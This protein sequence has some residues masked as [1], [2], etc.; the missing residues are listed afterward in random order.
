MTPQDFAKYGMEIVKVKT[1]AGKLQGPSGVVTE[2]PESSVY[3]L[4]EKGGY[5][6]SAG[7]RDIQGF[8]PSQYQ[9][10]NIKEFTTPTG[11][12]EDR[13][14]ANQFEAGALA[15]M[16]Y[17][18]ANTSKANIQASELGNIFSNYQARAQEEERA[19]AQSRQI[20]EQNRIAMQ[21]YTPS[22][23]TRAQQIQAQNQAL[24]GMTN[25]QI[26]AQGAAL[27]PD[28]AKQNPYNNTTPTFQTSGGQPFVPPNQDAGMARNL[29]AEQDFVKGWQGKGGRLP[30]ANEI[31]QAVYG[32]PNPQFNVPIRPSQTQATSQQQASTSGPTPEQAV[33]T[34]DLAKEQAFVQSWGGK[35]GRL[36]TAAEINQGV[37]GTA[38]PQFSTT[39][40]IRPPE[41]QGQAQTQTSSILGSVTTPTPTP[42]PAT[43]TSPED[44]IIKLLRE[45]GVKTPEQLSAQ[46][47]YDATMKQMQDDLIKIRSQQIPMGFITGQSRIEADVMGNKLAT[48]EQKLARLAQERSEK[49][50][51]A[52]DVYGVQSKVSTEKKA[53]EKAKNDALIELAKAGFSE[54]SSKSEQEKL[55]SQGYTE[56]PYGGKVYMKAPEKKASTAPASV[57]EYEYAKSQ[58]YTGSFSDYQNADANRKALVDRTLA[59]LSPAAQSAAFK[60]S[61]DYEKASKDIGTQVGAYNKIQAAAANPSAAGDLSMIFSYMKL[62]DPTS[63]V[64]EQEFANAQNAAGVPD[65]IRNMYN[66]ALSGERLN[67]NQRRD[68]VNTAKTLYQTALNQQA[69]IDQ[70]FTDR[71]NQWGVPPSLVVR[72]QGSYMDTPQPG[73]QPQGSQGGAFNYSAA[74][75]AA[76]GQGKSDGEILKWLQDK[77]LAPGMSV[78]NPKS[79]LDDLK[80]KSPSSVIKVSSGM[81]TDRHNNPVAFQYEGF[82]KMLEKV[83][84]KE[85]QDFSKGDAWSDNPNAHTVAFKDPETGIDAAIAIIDNYGFYTSSG[86]QRWSHTAMPQSEWNRLSEPEKRSVVAKMYQ[87]EGG[88]QLKSYFA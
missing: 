85:G 63:V 50:Q 55:R 10:L 9:G 24:K 37:Y 39:Q 80:K 35:M 8:D 14:M 76:R 68:F 25:E 86:K 18:G 4:Y 22:D 30:T 72:G 62:L 71:A 65:Q 66:R 43:T 83:G 23:P 41:P 48:M 70:Q 74:I 12:W 59:G 29:K 34:R 54:I 16:G 61:D 78:A 57:Q 87:K 28:L 46:G 40:G 15:K 32:T 31:N 36:P 17:G 45:G 53:E 20:E 21:N 7:F 67:E 19:A 11:R 64:R 49:R 33:I 42:P 44:E 56:V 58:G 5:G 13:D 47:E 51:A 6:Q 77:G 81:R 88:T 2:T 79:Y 52:L 38:N 82:N 1:P 3:K 26:Y 84:F 27:Y 60:L 73:A 75:D 69:I